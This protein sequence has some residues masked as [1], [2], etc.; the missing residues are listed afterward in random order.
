VSRSSY[1][2]QVRDVLASRPNE[3]AIDCDGIP[4][5][6]RQAQTVAASVERLLE[7]TGVPEFGRVGLIARNR[8]FHIAALWGIFIA[9]RCTSM[10]YAFQR[11]DS[12]AADI[13]ENRWPI[14]F[15]ERRD[16]TAPVI[17][18]ADDVGTAGYAFTDDPRAPFICVTQRPSPLPELLATPEDDTI[19]QLLSSGTTGKPKRISLSVRSID[20][21]ID[22]TRFQFASGGASEKAAQ[23]VPWPLSSLGGTNAALPAVS[24]GQ[25]L[26]IQERF[27]AAGFL[28]QLR[29]YRPSFLSMPPAAM[30]MLLQ[31][32]P[33]R[34]DLSCVELYF[35]G[36]APLDPNVRTALEEDYGLVVANAYGATEFAGI[37]SSWVP[38]DLAL[39]KAKRGSCGR[40]L[41]GMRMRI[42]SPETGDVL[43]TG[44]VGLVEALVPR[45]SD[46][47]VRTNDLA[48]MDED[49]FLYLQGRADDAI[50]RGGFKVIPEEVAEVLRLHP[51][52]GDAALIGIP[53]ERLGMVP[54]AA[55]EKRTGEEA[56]TPD[57]LDSY[58]RSRLPAYKIPVRYAIV[59]AIPRT[60]S[61]KPQR[62]GLRALFT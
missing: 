9:G 17:A 2:A 57:E 48:S 38:E 31:L 50:I 28:E 55:V 40:A 58:L 35:N 3:I 5:F 8:P 54:A 1:E 36:A 37:I 60:P 4:F 59:A 62:E 47:W 25:L 24:L 51:K 32:K 12:L 16:W 34:E 52:V 30:A 26:V 42:V 33:T 46:D 18:A 21:L 6:W 7:T 45:V 19:I 56:P 39:I 44:E 11:P 53:D 13:S 23:V 61:M 43:P 20:D 10:I 15:G 14:V 22:R 49:G 27:D 29:K 41:P